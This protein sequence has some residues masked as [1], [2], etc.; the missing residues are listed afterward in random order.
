MLPDAISIKPQRHVPVP[1]NQSIS[2]HH[3]R[4]VLPFTNNV[5]NV[6]GEGSERN[7]GDKLEV[8]EQEDSE[9][10]KSVEHV[11]EQ[12]TCVLALESVVTHHELGYT[13]TFD[14]IA[15]YRLVL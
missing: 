13:G 12:I 9:Y 10:V 14:C 5:T 6:A 8:A 2:S 11:L 3:R 7:L 1:D 4:S 15:K